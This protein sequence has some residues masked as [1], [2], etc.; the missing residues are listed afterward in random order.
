MIA[1]AIQFLV[2]LAPSIV[3]GIIGCV[4][5]L[6]LDSVVRKA[7]EERAARRDYPMCTR[8]PHN[9]SPCNGYPRPDCPGFL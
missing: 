4:L 8:P 9:E 2:T 3:G 6:G 1:A 5:V 7:R